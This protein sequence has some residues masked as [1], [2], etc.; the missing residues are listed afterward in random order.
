[1]TGNNSE[2]RL[3]IIKDASKIARQV[4]VETDFDEI[5]ASRD[6]QDEFASRI[7]T[8][9]NTGTVAQFL[10]NLASKWGVRSIDDPNDEIV[11]LVEKYDLGEADVSSNKFLRTVREN[12]TLTVLMVKNQGDQE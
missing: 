7:A 10:D 2:Q 4:W 12:N 11:D 8:A 9:T 6:I 5:D 3:E 1:M